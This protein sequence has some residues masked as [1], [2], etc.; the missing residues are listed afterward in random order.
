MVIAYIPQKLFPTMLFMALLAM[1]FFFAKQIGDPTNK[2]LN[3]DND[4][5]I[6]NS[7]LITPLN[8]AFE[9]L[10]SDPAQFTKVDL[11]DVPWS[12]KQH[13]YWLR[14]D[15]K[16]NSHEPT[17]LVSHF[18]NVMLDELSI[19]KYS[20]P[21]K[22]SPD[23]QSP[24]F[25]VNQQHVGDH[26]EDL[27]LAQ[28]TSPHYQFDI[29]ANEQVTL[30]VRIAT[31]GISQTSILF[32]HVE[33]FTNLVE[34]NHLLWGVFI[35][36]TII[37]AL[38]NLVLYFAAKDFVYLIY[39]GYIIF[40][41]ALMGAVLGY[42]FYVF[43]VSLQLFIHQQIIAIN[44]L[45]I[46]FLVLFL[47]YFLKFQVE[48]RWPFWLAMLIAKIFLLLCLVSLFIP[49]YLGAQILFILVPL[50]FVLCFILLFT[51]MREGVQWGVLYIY[52]WV[53][54][55]ICG[56]I[57]PLV[58]MGKIEYSFLSHHAF[59]IAILAEV[60][61]MAMAL[62]DRMRYQKEQV[63][64]HATYNTI[65]DLPNQTLL[66]THI[67]R[68]LTEQKAFASCLIEIEN[69]STLAPY[70]STDALLTLERQVIK[71]ISPILADEANVHVI[72]A[73]D[74]VNIK[75]AIVADG[76]LM[77]IFDVSDKNKVE[78]FAHKIQNKITK[79]ISL[80]GLLIDL[81][82]N[83]GICFSGTSEN[84]NSANKLIQYARL[85]IEQ[86]R[87]NEDQI[88]FYHELAVL[89]IK[90]HLE[91][92]CDLQKAIRGNKLM[93]YHQPQIILKTGEIYG[94][95][96]L[97]RWKHP[98][99]GFISPEL[100]VKVAEDTGL[101]N[102]LTL[103]V[104]EQA[105]KQVH[106]LRQHTDL[107][108]KISLNISGKD[109]GLSN[110]LPFVKEKLILFN[111]PRDMITF[112][113]TESVM[114]T[115][116][117][118]L[119]NLMLSLSELG[120]NVSIDDYGTGY[121]SLNYISQ[122]KFDELKIDKAFVLDLDHSSRNLAIVKATIDMAK[123]LK[124]KVVAEGVES[125]SIEQKLKESGC[126]IVQGYYYS[127]PLPFDEYLIWLD[128]YQADR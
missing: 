10:I 42:G 65:I 76:Q 104:I 22:Q 23:N 102:E 41:V 124:L 86:N 47:V 36:V 98:E 119:D 54:L 28:R 18:D 103:W 59:M 58:L 9:T 72:S 11:K 38:Y 26:L 100:F 128:N 110:L 32:Y 7:Y 15:I 78:H 66:E 57:Q 39:N 50:A 89:D 85:A 52:S 44:C 71:D 49:E 68:L 14:F 108:Q 30:Y 81:K 29:G 94:S 27:A 62:A 116:F 31:T 84:T 1:I 45:L 4:F 61:L 55:L 107:Q 6:E 95:E 60:V 16:N 64:Y 35:G 8:V 79:E 109:I 91:L 77:F 80:D 2:N 120:I 123:N 73:K 111:I 127:K 19:Y 82:T 88:H 17:Q 105:F 118:T 46:I 96:L 63:I 13:A 112:E 3:H 99:H 37:F 69:Y 70:L 51:K 90:V 48:K 93:L 21:D 114:V 40:C 25:I 122:L 121:S 101:I 74:K 24:G 106:R 53:P 20:S 5:N 83:I 92:A 75:I 87:E 34:K 117:S 115:D 97:L 113:L 126:D 33:D 67:T 43:P 125:K 12:F 56:A